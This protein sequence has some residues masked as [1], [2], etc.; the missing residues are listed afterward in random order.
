[1]KTKKAYGPGLGGMPF[2]EIGGGP[3][4]ACGYAGPSI[5]ASLHAL[6]AVSIKIL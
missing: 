5:P 3:A 1:M 6:A 4:S 2:Y